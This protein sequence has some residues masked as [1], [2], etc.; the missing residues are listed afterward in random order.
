MHE[1]PRYEYT[2]TRR[3]FLI[4]GALLIASG[5]ALV[6]S[7]L[8]FL[9]LPEGDETWIYVRPNQ[10]LPAPQVLGAAQA[11]AYVEEYRLVI[12]KLGVDAP[13]AAFGLDEEGIPQVPFEKNLVA[14]YNFSAVPG[15]GGNAVF[16]GHRTWNGDAVFRHLEDLAPGDIIR[17]RTPAGDELVY[18]VS[19]E[20]MVGENDP[21]GVQWMG[22]TEVD[23]ITLI[24]CGGNYRRTNDAFGGAYDA[25]AVVRATLVGAQ[26][27]AAPPG[28]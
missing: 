1:P 26:P 11:P 18:E 12:D 9:V 5:A 22:P 16:A 20:G 27:A 2:G 21:S 13:V 7:A 17:L 24:T 10:P 3:F 25:R 19:E 23:S 14:W 6:G 4:L 28:S 15:T 8:Y